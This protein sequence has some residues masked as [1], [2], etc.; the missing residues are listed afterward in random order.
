MLEWIPTEEQEAHIL[1]KELSRGKFKFHRGKI[2]VS[3]NPF[4]VRGSVEN[5]TKKYSNLIFVWIKLE[6]NCNS[7]SQEKFND[8]NKLFWLSW[9]I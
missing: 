3:N 1:M 8:L 2:R 9:F 7:T 6:E 5:G 4:I